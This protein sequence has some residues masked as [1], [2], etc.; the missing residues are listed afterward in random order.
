MERILEKIYTEVIK[1]DNVIN[2]DEKHRAREKTRGE[3]IVGLSKIKI[4]KAAADDKIKPE[5]VLL[6]KV[7]HRTHIVRVLVGAPEGQSRYQDPGIVQ[8]GG[9]VYKCRSDS[10][11]VCDQIPFDRTKTL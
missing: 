6:E 1:K 11:S 4:G 3:V 2:E 5:M 9:T 7:K 8:R 10:D